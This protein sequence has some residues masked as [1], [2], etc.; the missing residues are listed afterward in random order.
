M[1]AA[2]NLKHDLCPCL[3]VLSRIKQL[4]QS[5]LQ[6]AFVNPA[7]LAAFPLKRGGIINTSL[8]DIPPAK[9]NILALSLNQQ[10]GETGLTAGQSEPPDGTKQQPATVDKEGWRVRKRGGR[11]IQQSDMHST[12]RGLFCC[13]HSPLSLFS[14]TSTTSPAWRLISAGSCFS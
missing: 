8:E 11:F 14:M 12:R 5:S 7:C 4:T 3:L 10:W 6:L 13:D 9:G 1:G 2:Q